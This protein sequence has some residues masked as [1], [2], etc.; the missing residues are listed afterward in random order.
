MDVLFSKSQ[1]KAQ[2]V[3]LKFKRYLLDVINWDSR[4]IA[5]KGARGSGKTTILLQYMALHLPKDSTVLYI[6]MDDLFFINKSLYELAQTF[7]KYGGQFLLVDEVHKY[8]NWSREIK[9]IYDDLPDLKLIFTSS[10]ILNIY[11]GESDLSRR[12]AT[13]NLKELSLREFVFLEKN[14]ELPTYTLEEILR[15]HQEIATAI[16]S[17]IKPLEAFQKYIKYGA[18]PYFNDGIHNYEQSLIQ[19]VNL[20]IDV[21]LNAVAT[22]HFDTLVKIKKLLFSIATSVPFTPNISKLSQLT[23]LSRPT[24]I[25][26]LK[27]LESARLIHQLSKL[28]SGIGALRKPEKLYINNSN[29]LKVLSNDSWKTGTIRETFFVNQLSGIIDLHLSDKADFIIDKTYTIEIGGK[30]KT[31]KQLKNTPKAFVVKDDIEYGS[32]NTI[33]LWLF[34]FLY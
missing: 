34:G 20:I 30:G 31:K 18:Y 28:T 21:D 9:L 19:I 4:L 6:A 17:K 2:R 10:S 29:L 24:L 3:P 23:G 16:N 25:Q 7:V 27:L 12:V 33:P 15:N 5:I 8:P 14:I 32:L 26:L 22:L 1:E 11:A 13:Y